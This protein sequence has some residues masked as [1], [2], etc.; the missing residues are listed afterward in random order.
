MTQKTKLERQIESSV[1]RV[2]S[3]KRVVNASHD[4][5]NVGVISKLDRFNRGDFVA[6]RNINDAISLTQITDGALQSVNEMLKRLYEL[7]VQANS[8]HYSLEQKVLLQ[9]EAVELLK[10]VHEVLDGAEFNGIKLFDV[11]GT[12]TVQSGG[13]TGNT[14]N[15]EKKAI[16][17]YTLGINT[18]DVSSSASFHDLSTAIDIVNTQLAKT[19]AYMNRLE[20]Q[21]QTMGTKTFNQ[22]T[23]K[24]RMED[25]D[26]AMEISNLAKNKI[27]LNASFMSLKQY[28]TEM[29]SYIHLV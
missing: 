7:T 6:K 20:Y 5:G 29:G 16:S 9:T 2:T 26:L 3:G 18:L 19:G 10:T 23:S 28:Q 17:I 13:D 4:A 21:H 8:D 12:I 11:D 27:L 25:A 1:D 22:I 15:I 24:S 14:M